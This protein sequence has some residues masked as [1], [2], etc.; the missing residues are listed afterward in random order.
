MPYKSKAQMR[1]MHAQHPEIAKRWDA[2]M[3]ANHQTMKG[4][5]EHVRKAMPKP[6]KR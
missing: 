4:K 1:M 5:P 2:E 6:R 3:K